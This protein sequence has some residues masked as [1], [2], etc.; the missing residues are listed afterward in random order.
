[1]AQ[2]VLREV[3]SH[4]IGAPNQEPYG[5]LLGHVVYCPWTLVPYV[6][7]DA[8][9]RETHDVPHGG[10]QDVFRRTWASA[11]RD[12]RRR[13][14][15]VI[16]WYHQHGVLGLRLSQWDQQLQEE[17]FPEPWHCA[18]LIVPGARGPIGGFVQ[19][20]GRARLYRRGISSF[21]ELVDLD[22]KS[23]NGKKPSV[24][25][26]TNHR[27]AERVEIQ[28]V[29]WPDPRRRRAAIPKE[30]VGDPQPEVS[31]SVTPLRKARFELDKDAEKPDPASSDWQPTG[32][33]GLKARPWKTRKTPLAGKPAAERR[34]LAEG[35]AEAVGKRQTK[36]EAKSAAEGEV[37]P[38]ES[39]VAPSPL[40]LDDGEIAHFMEAVWGPTPYEAEVGEDL[41]TKLPDFVELLPLE[42][43]EVI[44]DADLASAMVIPPVLEARST[45]EPPE[46]DSAEASMDW[47]LGLVEQTL[48]G[49]LATPVRKGVEG[50]EDDD[51]EGDASTAD[52]QPLKDEEPDSSGVGAAASEA[53]ATPPEASR[54]PVAAPDTVVPVTTRE[55]IAARKPRVAL[56]GETD[57]PEEDPEAAI[58]IVMPS[59]EGWDLLRLLRLRRR[60][61]L[62]AVLA[63]VA[64]LSIWF[65]M[66][67]QDRAQSDF[68]TPA[69]ATTQP[70][71]SAELAELETEFTAALAAYRERAADFLLGRIDC[72]GLR[73]GLESVEAVF[74]E[75]SGL[76]ARVPDEATG[77]WQ[78]AREMR[79]ANDHFAAAGCE[80]TETGAPGSVP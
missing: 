49:S 58:P 41:V 6:V 62:L 19:R 10:D 20:S 59:A 37:T 72:A 75:I 60:P 35:F 7:V 31:S 14:G 45:L 66:D 65:I 70:T 9:R 32:G 3:R 25:D 73:T 52:S 8:V 21:Y 33:A 63:V 74:M 27:P 23:I 54:E 43:P 64:A 15:Q 11:A 68:Q 47:L 12:A 80:G 53:K 17:F 56:V 30:G 69:P 61:V 76:S 78:Q 79:E 34:E 26:W 50:G 55:D 4:L 24:V 48:G 39:G 71:R 16:G 29:Q 57:D 38:D 18:L 2:S 77:Y 67:R 40:N 1:V 42:G 13:R 36:H 44:S 22:A 46:I 51:D 28:R 5:F